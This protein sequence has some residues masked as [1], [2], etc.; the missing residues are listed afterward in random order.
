[1]EIVEGSRVKV[2]DPSL[3]LDD[4]KTPLSITM[5]LATVVCRYGYRS[6]HV[7]YM[8]GPN[9][10]VGCTYPDCVDVIFDHRPDK[11]SKGHFTESIAVIK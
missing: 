6:E 4:I 1:M 7:R 3:F 11:V 2:F 10:G 9:E 8:S 5:K